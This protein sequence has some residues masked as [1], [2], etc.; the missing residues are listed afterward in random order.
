M[1][2]LVKLRADEQL[3]HLGPSKRLSVTAHEVRDAHRGSPISIAQWRVIGN[4]FVVL[5]CAQC[6][7]VPS[8]VSFSV[9]RIDL[10]PRPISSAVHHVEV[11][12]TRDADAASL[13]GNKCPSS[14]GEHAHA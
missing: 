1:L 14:D 7:A 9:S 3:F 8:H 5:D 11:T 6:A 10:D 12:I 4:G 2:R 13:I